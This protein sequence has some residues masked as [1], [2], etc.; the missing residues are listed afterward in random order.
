MK[1]KLKKLERF[2]LLDEI[3]RNTTSTDEKFE[4]IAKKIRIK[5]KCY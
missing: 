3:L 4:S 1:N 5:R 2:T